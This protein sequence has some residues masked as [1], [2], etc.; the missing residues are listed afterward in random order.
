MTDEE[1]VLD[2]NARFYAAFNDK[3]AEAMDSLWARTLPVACIHPGWSALRDRARVLASWRGIL[4]NPGAPRIRV[5]EPSVHLLGEVAFVI[6]YEHVGGGRLHATNIIAREDGAFRMVHHQAG[7][8]TS[9]T[10][11]DEEDVE[12]KPDRSKLN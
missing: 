12:T 2:L 3:D 7:P 1:E 11:T 4:G 6:C 8:S 10:P 9:Q 5:S